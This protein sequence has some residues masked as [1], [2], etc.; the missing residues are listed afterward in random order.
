MFYLVILVVAL[1]AL[2]GAQIAG[3]CQETSDPYE[4]IWTGDILLADAA[5]P[6]LDKHGYTW[7]FEYV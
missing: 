1:V 5:Q 4:I 6:Y 2:G 3:G 7:P